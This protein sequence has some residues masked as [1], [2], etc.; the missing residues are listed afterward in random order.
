MSHPETGAQSG[1]EDPAQSGTGSQDGNSST[2]G[3]AGTG[4]EGSGAQSG[5][6]SDNSGSTASTVPAEE[7]ERQ[8]ERTRAADQRAADLQRQLKEIQDKD[9][10]EL[11][12][13]KRDFQEAAAERD[14]LREANRQITLE[15]AF[16]EDNKYKWKNPKTALKLADLTK[17][18][19]EDDGK[20]TG[21]TAALDA[22]A[23]SDP[24]LLDSD[25]GSGEEGNQQRGATGAS[26]SG[27][28][29]SNST[30]TDLKKM[31]V[32]IPALRSRGLGTS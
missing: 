30:G 11:E 10:P 25:T 5:A 29:Q 4:T 3:N 1:T 22:L 7:L 21:L 31:S 28:R 24:Y 18:E 8:R 12:K 23:K 19:V 13:L 6:G 15:K 14:K 26:G 17:V 2:G 16:L 20:V 9:L 32:R 27:G